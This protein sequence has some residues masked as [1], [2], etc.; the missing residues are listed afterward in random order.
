MDSKCTLPIQIVVGTSTTTTSKNNPENRIVQQKFVSFDVV[1]EDKNEFAPKFATEELAININENT[2]ID[3]KIPIESA[4]D[5]DSRQSEIVYSIVPVD[6]YDQEV[7]DEAAIEHLNSRIH[8]KTSSPIH[9]AQQ[10]DSFNTQKLNLILLKPFDYEKEKSLRFKILAADGTKT[11]SQLVTLKVIDLNDN[12]PVFDRPEYEYR[13]DENSATPGTKLIRVHATD[14]DDGLNGLLKYSFV[15]TTIKSDRANHQPVHIKDLFQIDETSGWIR[16]HETAHLDYEHIPTYRLTVKAQDQGLSNSMPV[17]TNVIIYLN[18]VN[19]NPPVISLTLPS[20]IDDFNSENY[21]AEAKLI[22]NLEISEWTR[23]D[24]FLAQVKISDADSNLNSKLKITLHQL[25]RNSIENTQWILSN[26]FSL[27]HL[28]NNIYSLMTKERLDRETFDLY[29]LNITV[30]DSGQP[31]P[32][33]TT[34]ELTVRIKDEND[35]KPIFINENGQDVKAYEF[36]MLELKRNTPEKWVVIGSVLATDKDINHNGRITY[37]LKPLNRTNC[38]STDG[39]FKVN[40]ESGVI[41]A[42]ESALDREICDKYQ[43]SVIANDNYKSTNGNSVSN[44]IVAKLTV[45]LIDIND[46][47]PVFEQDFYRFEIVENLNAIKFG[48]VRASDADKQNNKNSLVR[49]KFAN[50]METNGFFRVN[51]LTGDLILLKVIFTF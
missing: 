5:R 26:D 30:S 7:N 4:I 34:H 17:Y 15:D 48:Q 42:R 14:N 31:K 16:V 50:D 51:E 2:P 28:F 49:Y 32:L 21:A 45:N 46:N 11:G 29:S 10:S 3:F 8:L 35:N 12:L 18:D 24:T 19:D 40:I 9:Q 33:H 47:A 20:T 6:D 36:N 22:Q 27:V 25:K 44:E 41:K 23:P 37:S 1:I 13:L 43:F 38:T 39:L